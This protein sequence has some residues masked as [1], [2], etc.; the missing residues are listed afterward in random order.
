MM[1]TFN[2]IRSVIPAA[3]HKVNSLE[4]IIDVGCIFQPATN[5]DLG[6]LAWTAI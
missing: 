4:G 3:V 6:Q 1:L 5:R 2:T